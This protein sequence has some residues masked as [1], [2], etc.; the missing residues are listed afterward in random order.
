MGFDEPSTFFWLC[1][2]WFRGEPHGRSDM[3]GR[4][5]LLCVDHEIHEIGAAISNFTDNVIVQL[6]LIA[7]TSRC[8]GL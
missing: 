7:T 4:S 3:L 1:E 2:P 6:L 8:S 5:P